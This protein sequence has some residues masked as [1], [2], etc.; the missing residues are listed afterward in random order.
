MYQA[1]SAVLPRPVIQDRQTTLLTAFE[2]FP[3]GLKG[4][5]PFLFHIAIG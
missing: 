2:V 4:A 1:V 3:C 5:L